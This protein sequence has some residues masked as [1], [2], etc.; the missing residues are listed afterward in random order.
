MVEDFG[1]KPW[2]RHLQATPLAGKIEVGASLPT[3]IF[4]RKFRGA[5]QARL[6]LRVYTIT[7]PA[8]CR[9]VFLQNSTFIGRLLLNQIH[10]TW[11]N[12]GKDRQGWSG[13]VPHKYRLVTRI[14]LRVCFGYSNSMLLRLFRAS[15][16]LQFAH[17]LF[18][19]KEIVDKLA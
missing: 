8:A 17:S 16:C 3:R 9:R 4:L 2:L 10:C 19:L 6:R 15:L 14:E 13:L 11:F 18:L 12:R 1:D 7:L 5:L